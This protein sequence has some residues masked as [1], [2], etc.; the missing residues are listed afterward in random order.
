L[1]VIPGFADVPMDDGVVTALTFRIR[2]E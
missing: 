1:L 2:T